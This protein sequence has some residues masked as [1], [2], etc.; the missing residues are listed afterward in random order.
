MISFCSKEKLLDGIN[1][2]K[3]DLIYG[4]IIDS[5]NFDQTNYINYLQ[6][7]ER[8]RGIKLEGKDI[9]FKPK[10]FNNQPNLIYI[11]NFE[12]ID[13]EFSSFLLHKFG[14]DI[15]MYKAYYAKIEDKIFLIIDFDQTFIYEIIGTNQDKSDIIVEYLIEVLISIKGK[16]FS[17]NTAS[18]NQLIFKYL[19]TNGIKKLIIMSQNNF[20]TID[21]NISL[22]F[23]PINKLHE[24]NTNSEKIIAVNFRTSD[25]ILI[26]LWQAKTQIL[27][28]ILKKDFIMNFLN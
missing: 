20:I 16:S 13:Q 23:H 22:K 28:Q 8:P 25:K 7:I 6:R 17:Y 4:R 10:Y 27:F 1:Y 24:Q 9:I 18:L 3:C 2:Q 15:L 11:D 19:S 21:N 12:I 26:F 14:A 5:L